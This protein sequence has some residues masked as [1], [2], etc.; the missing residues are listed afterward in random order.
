[1]QQVGI[2]MVMRTTWGSIGS[3]LRRAVVADKGDVK[4]NS[5]K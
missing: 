1:M 5:A 3:L 4:E 2:G